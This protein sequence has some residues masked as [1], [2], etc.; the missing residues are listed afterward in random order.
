MRCPL[1]RTAVF[2]STDVK[3][4]TWLMAAFCALL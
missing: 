3:L 2:L 1:T 4:I